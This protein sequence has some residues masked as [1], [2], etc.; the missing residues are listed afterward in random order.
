MAGKPDQRVDF[1]TEPVRIAR[2][3]R[4]DG[5]FANPFGALPTE[6]RPTSRQDFRVSYIWSCVHSA[7]VRRPRSR[8]A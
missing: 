7:I 8:S 1:G 6:K 4:E 2:N 3:L 5:A